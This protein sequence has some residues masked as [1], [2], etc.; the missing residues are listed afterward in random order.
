MLP[1]IPDDGVEP[2]LY[3]M[4]A[5]V[6]A[7]I[8]D[9]EAADWTRAGDMH[10]IRRMPDG[11][12]VMFEWQFGKAEFRNYL[13]RSNGAQRAAFITAAGTLLKNNTDTLD[14]LEN[15]PAGVKAMGFIPR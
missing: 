6:I 11:S 3:E 13:E 15:L 9:A 2:V 14:K 5:F 7:Q 4:V 1:S 8:P 12:Q 10:F